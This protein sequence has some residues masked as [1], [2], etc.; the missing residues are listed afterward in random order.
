MRH[1]LSGLLLLS[2]MSP[3]AAAET[4]TANP[5]P[6]E[7]FNR[8]VFTFDMQLDRYVL[9]PV[10]V[11]YSTVTPS[12]GQ[13]MVHNFF[14]NLKDVRSSINALFQ[15]RVGQAGSDMGRVLINTSMG[16]GGLFDVATDAGLKSHDQDFGLTLARWGVP[17]G[18]YLV[19]PFLGPSTVRDGIALTPD[20][21]IWPPHYIDDNWIAYGGT[22]LYVVSQRSELLNL[23]KSIIG[24]KYIFVRNYYLQ[25]RSLA[26]GKVV[27][28]D[29]GS[30]AGDSDQSGGW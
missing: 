12:W 25:S 14:A 28:D 19:L 6:W 30:G 11:G 8:K 27:K 5:D 24:D 13:Q 18:P 9:K 17:P 1:L 21:Y 29:F 20:I 2:L 26:A 22:G 10:A 23:E 3:L 16:V 15:G 7:G 4:A